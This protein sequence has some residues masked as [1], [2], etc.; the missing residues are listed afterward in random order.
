[1]ALEGLTIRVTATFTGNNGVLEGVLSEPT[2]ALAAASVTPA[3]AGDDTI[4]GTIAADTID[5]LAGDDT[6]QAFGGNDTIIGGAGV[7]NPAKDVQR[8]LG[9][10]NRI[11]GCEWQCC[12]ALPGPLRIGHAER[13]GHDEDGD[14]GCL[15]FHAAQ[16]LGRACSMSG[17]GFF[18]IAQRF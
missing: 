16:F 12:A 5:A 1:M 6:V 13:V 3:T 7:D 17:D 15:E 10:F 9:Q 2:I 11:G 4:F 14:V 18:N 8:S